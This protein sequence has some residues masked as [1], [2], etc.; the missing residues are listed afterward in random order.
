MY[1][2]TVGEKNHTDSIY[3]RYPGLSNADNFSNIN[4]HIVSCF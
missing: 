2:L 1:K 3:E 4:N